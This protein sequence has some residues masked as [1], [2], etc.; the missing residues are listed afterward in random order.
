MS[1]NYRIIEVRRNLRRSFSCVPVHLPL[2]KVGLTTAS[3]L[4]YCPVGFWMSPRTDTPQPFWTA[5]IIIWPSSYWKSLLWCLNGICCSS[6]CVHCLLSCHWIS[7]SLDPS[8]LLPSPASVPGE[9]FI[10]TG[11]ISCPCVPLWSFLFCRL[12]DPSSHRIRCFKLFHDL[13]GPSLGLVQQALPCTGEPST[14]HST[15]G[16]ASPVL[17][18]EQQSPHSTSRQ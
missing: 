18:W 17:S 1:W 10:H 4:E 8:S 15:P 14:G 11:E 2:F 16:M 5:C 3:L 6:A 9:V 12:N 7:L 13:N